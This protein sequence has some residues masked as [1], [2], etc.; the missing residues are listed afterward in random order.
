MAVELS[1]TAPNNTFA[2]GKSELRVLSGEPPSAASHINLSY[3][4]ILECA[5]SDQSS[6]QTTLATTYTDN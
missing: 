1:S 5:H 4:T 3:Y 6:H 2:F